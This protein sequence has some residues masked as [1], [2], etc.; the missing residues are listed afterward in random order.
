MPANDKV[1]TIGFSA[2]SLFDTQQAE[3]VYE[4]EGLK[5]YLSFLKKMDEN[6][7]G[8]GPGPALGLYMAF[9]KLKDIIPK[10]VLDIRFGMV[11]KHGPNE[12]SDPLFNAYRKLIAD[13]SSDNI[14]ITKE[15]DYMHLTNGDDP[16]PYHKIQG[17]DLVITTS[18]E[19][20]KKYY[21]NGVAAIYIPNKNPETNMALYKKRN[22]KIVLVSDFDGVI[23]DVN[24]ELNYQSAKLDKTLDPLEVFRK[25]EFENR[26]IPMELGPLG[27]VVKKLGNVVQFF[28]EKRIEGLLKAEDMPYETIVVTARGGS[29]FE[30]YKN[31]KKAYNIFVTQSHLMDGVNKNNIL[32]LIAN[33]RKDANILFIDD[34]QVHFDRANDLKEILAGFVHNDHTVG[35]LLPNLE[36][37]Q[38]TALTQKLSKP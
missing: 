15:L 19:S 6:G 2:G 31:T 38:K 26:D 13:D 28:E 32:E 16:V 36:H 37:L 12:E 22:N 34:G 33:K 27:N 7:E 30:R 8:F 17:A 11:S 5:A 23:G 18:T 20:A 4:K 21:E 14:S 1:L 24:S 10:D 25:R 3:N 35:K 9:R 29:A